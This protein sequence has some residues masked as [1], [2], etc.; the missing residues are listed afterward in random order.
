[1]DK[2][3]GRP[4]WED[5]SRLPL[6]A[7]RGRQ[8]WEDRE[9]ICSER[10]LLTIQQMVL[11]DNE[12]SGLSE[13]SLWNVWLMGSG[14]KTLVISD[15]RRVN[16]HCVPL[17][18]HEGGSGFKNRFILTLKPKNWNTWWS[19]CLFIFRLLLFFCTVQLLLFELIQWSG[20]LTF[21]FSN[22]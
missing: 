20:A 3:R 5:I 13:V 18:H 14:R 2:V 8:Q 12:T 1:M 7:V 19:V 11:R 17:K 21:V 6:T 10:T 16:S 9:D 4:Q 22:F 15:T